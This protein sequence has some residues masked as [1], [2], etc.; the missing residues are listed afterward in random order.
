MEPGSRRPGAAGALARRP[1]MRDEGSAGRWS[2]VVLAEPAWRR[3]VP[4]AEAL[5]RRAAAAALR[6][7]GAAGSVTVLLAD[8]RE[9][10]A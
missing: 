7:A 5:A 8:D 3:L 2:I 10:G 4:R 9:C 6:E 1:G